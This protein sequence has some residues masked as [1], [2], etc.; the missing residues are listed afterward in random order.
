GAILGPIAVLNAA[1]RTAQSHVLV[2]VLMVSTAL[3]WLVLGLAFVQEFLQLSLFDTLL[4][5]LGFMAVVAFAIIAVIG[6]IIS[7]RPWP[8]MDED[9]EAPRQRHGPLA[10]SMR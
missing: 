7:I 9:G 10:S 6:F 3:V 5:R 1:R 8:A 4:V 2:T